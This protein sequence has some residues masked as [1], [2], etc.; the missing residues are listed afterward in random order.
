[1]AKNW[2]ALAAVLVLAACSS[3][4]GSTVASTTTAAK[5]AGTA[6]SSAQT[7]ALRGPT[8]PTEYVGLTTQIPI[9]RASFDDT[10]SKLFGAD[11]AKG[12]YLEN[13]DVGTG[14]HLA[15]SEHPTASDEVA[16]TVTMETTGAKPPTRTV[17]SVPASTATG[18]TFIDAVDAAMAQTDK[19]S[20]EDPDGLAPWRIEYRSRSAQ[21]GKVTVGVVF[22]PDTGTNL[23]LQ[24]QGPTTSLQP[25]RIN[26]AAAEGKPYETV[27]GLVWFDVERD[28]FDFFANR[29]YGISAGKS[30]NFKDFE[31]VPHNWLRLTVTPELDQDRVSVGFDVVTVDGRRIPVAKAPASLIAGEEFM[32][33]V[34]R[35]ADNT[36]AQEKAKPGSSTPWQ[37][38][39]YYDDPDG[40]GVVE[41]IAQGK[42]GVSQIAYSIES[43]ANELEDLPFVPYTGTVKVPKDWDK[44]A[45]TC[46]DVGSKASTK[47]EFE[48]TYQPSTTVKGSDLKAPLKGTVYGSVYKASDVKITGPLPGTTAVASIKDEG[49]DVVDGPSK[50]YP[51]GTD[52]PAG[53][54]QILGFLDIDGNA[55]PADPSPDEGDPVMIPIGGFDLA[56]AVQPV[57]AEF[58]IV[59]PPGVN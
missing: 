17:A 5:A 37:V 54:Y 34:F 4:A 14:L 33:T 46:K 25:D 20:K 38:P 18:S 13:L 12:S 52:L 51:L 45:P 35:M 43:P 10:A 59:L 50:A 21:G 41:V 56:C 40:G 39:F 27:Y 9:D 8:M 23:E 29:A 53:S 6:S 3:D 58:A 30:Q 57:T 42:D 32:Q 19:V 31:L 44:P 28:Q 11:A 49:V 7:V 47:G 26:K 2:V 15:S 48:I 24:A 55:D 16:L 1:V 22:D 36:A